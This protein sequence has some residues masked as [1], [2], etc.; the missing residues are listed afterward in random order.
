[1]IANLPTGVYFVHGASG[2]PLLVNARARQLLGQRE[3]LAAGISHL[4]DIYK[5]H[6]ANG[7][8]Y[9]WDELPV[10]KALH[11][12]A[13]TMRDDIVVHR[14]DGRHIPLVTWA[15]P[16]DLGGHGQPDAAVWVLED[17]TALRQSEEQYRGLVESLPLM[18]LQY[19]KDG[20]L[21]YHNPAAEQISGY[22]KESLK[23]P[24]FWLS[25]IDKADVPAFRSMVDAAR[26]GQSARAEFRFKGADGCE[27][28]GYALAQPRRPGGATVLVVDLTQRRRLEQELQKVQRLD[29][30]GRIASGVVHDFNNMLTVIVGYAELI[31]DSIGNHPAR[32]DVDQIFLATDQA[33]TLASQL[34]TFSKQ[35]QV[36]MR[37]IDLNA[38]TKHALDLLVP[39]MPDNIDIE[40]RGHNGAVMVLADDA[41][42]QQVIMNLCFN[43]RDAMP[44]GGKLF[45][46]TASEELPLR[47]PVVADAPAMT[48]G[49]RQWARLTVADSGTG[50]D[51]V[52][53]SRIFEPLF[54]TKER[55]SGLGLAVVKQVVEG[56]GG[57]IR[58][59]SAPGQGTHFDVWLPLRPG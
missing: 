54:T 6:K 21:C 2:R 38:L 19:D 25:C 58:V 17:L 26:D 46:E 14:P 47:D 39:T 45:V 55:G 13:S 51:E 56:F 35:R 41:P 49:V 16:V 57:C 8:I 15:A 18:L 34:L 37:P 20:A 22:S 31:R 33:R 29:L 59:T 50:M 10:Y 28:V 23:Q 52:V 40:V 11:G 12:G 27:K 24:E 32:A 7:Q 36:V 48:G 5:L 4:P 9:P 53:K 1:L 43:A 42:L 44:K 3:D 30:V